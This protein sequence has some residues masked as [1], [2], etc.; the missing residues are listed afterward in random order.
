MLLSW[1]SDF[2]ATHGP[3]NTVTASGSFALIILDTAHIGDTVVDTQSHTSGKCFLTIFT[4]AGQ[5]EVVFFLPSLAASAHS[6]ASAAAVMSPPRPTSII[7]LNPIFFKASRILV[8]EISLPNCPS[9]AGATIAYTGLPANISLIMSTTKVLD[10][11]APNGQLWIQCPH[12]IHFSS[13]ITQMP[14]SSKDI[15]S[16]G[17]ALLHG[18]IR[19]AMALYGHALEQSPHSLHW[20][21]SM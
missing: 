15:A 20:L 2:L 13:S 7:S 10:P 6:S 9:V 11:I 17:H 16:T 8:M 3:I 18:R 4:N 14:F 21:G 12:W 1:H 19:S 5:Q